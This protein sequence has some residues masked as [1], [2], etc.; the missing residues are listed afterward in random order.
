MAGS[1]P[2][3]TPTLTLTLSTLTLTLNPTLTQT[4]TQ[5]NPIPNRR[6]DTPWHKGV[7]G[8]VHDRGDADFVFARFASIDHLLR[9]V[10]EERIESVRCED[11]NEV[12]VGR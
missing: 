3:P 11:G 12:V 9:V 5:A 6:L 8:T 4:Q 7:W 1:T 2:T 10:S